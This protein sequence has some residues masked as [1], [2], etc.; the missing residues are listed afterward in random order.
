MILLE[1]RKTFNIAYSGR[2]SDYIA[3]PF[4]RNCKSNCLYCYVHRH[5]NDNKLRI[6]NNIDDILQSIEN[7]ANT[8]TIKQANQTD[9]KYWTYDIGCQSD[10]SIDAN[11][12]DYK[13]IFDTF[14]NNDKI[15]ATYAT[16]TLNTKLLK[17]NPDK[18]V[19]IRFSLTPD[20][21]L[22]K[23][24]SPLLKRIQGINMY[25]NA[26]YEVHINFSPII[27]KS[28]MQEEYLHIFDL[29]KQYV[30]KDV[31]NELKIEAI[32]LTHNEKL[33]NENT[34]KGYINEEKLLWNP[35]LQQE[36]VSGISKEI[37]VRYN[38]AIKE[39]A[40][41]WFVDLVNQ[42]LNIPIRY[43]F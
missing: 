31:Y 35:K 41:N 10:F 29:I 4:V 20:L 40:V 5:F 15:K 3:P 42:N 38:Q 8:L 25:Y 39:K 14:K 12:I 18:K 34:K 43:I 2:S 27:I 22:E 17:Y 6:A 28:K 16:K 9:E 30:N 13:L 33:H 19:R 23:G 24:T 37:N 26:G 7:H 36:K 11:Y 32:F 21:G 1:K